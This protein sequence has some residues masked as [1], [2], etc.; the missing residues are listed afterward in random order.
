MLL[1]SCEQEDVETNS[2]SKIKADNSHQHFKTLS[3]DKEF[4]NGEV[5]KNLDSRL[6]KNSSANQRT[7]DDGCESIYMVV[8]DEVH[9]FDNDPDWLVYTVQIAPTYAKDYDPAFY[10]NLV[11]ADYIGSAKTTGRS[12][13]SRED[14]AFI[15]TYDR[16]TKKLD[17]ITFIGEEPNANES[18]PCGYSYSEVTPCNCIDL[19]TGAPANHTDPGQ[20]DCWNVPGGSGPI[21]RA[22][23]ANPCESEIPC[24][25]TGFVSYSGN[26]SGGSGGEPTVNCIEEGDIPNYANGASG[27][28]P[29]FGGVNVPV[30]QE[31][32]SD[33]QTLVNLL[34]LDPTGDLADWVNDI[35]NFINVN[36]IL[37]F[38]GDNPSDEELSFA[39]EVIR[40]WNE[41]ADAEVDFEDRII[42]D[43][44]FD[45]EP[46]FKDNLDQLST[47]AI[48]SDYFDNFDGENPVAHLK[49]TASSFG[50]NK[51]ASTYPPQNFVI[52]I[53]FNTDKTNRPNTDIARTIMHEVIHAEIFR[54][55][56][57]LAQTGNLSGLT[58]QDVIDAK[59]DYPGIYDYYTRYI[60]NNPNPSSPQHDMMAQHLIGTLANFLMQFDSSLT[61][62]EAEAL[63]WSG[64]KAGVDADSN[65]EMDPQTG[66]IIDPVTG[67]N[68]STVAWTNLSQSERLSINQIRSNYMQNTPPCQ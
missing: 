9:L 66:L 43:S 4:K 49:F 35:G 5:F 36:E 18:F 17:R 39:I 33:R 38:L 56:L 65:S 23:E 22:I 26:E 61:L 31:F 68:E 15:A 52:E 37:S 32:T 28:P 47:N 67:A 12:S 44:S 30:V 3:F 6:K 51:N 21:V 42:R 20:C 60:Y 41:N 55:L 14:M 10:Q 27:L 25:P 11:I 40:T 45:N 57:S 34:N 64:L 19:S 1:I 63:A 8:D 2:T 58:E 59:D 48:A 46:C 24:D 53:R 54:K 13:S 16:K 29:C 7:N 50:N 62:S